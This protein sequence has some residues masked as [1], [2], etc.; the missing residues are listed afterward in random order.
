MKTKKLVY[1]ALFASLIAI[2]A[3]VA[4]PTQPIPLNM[5]LFAVLL[6]GGILGKKYGTLS[7]VVYILLGV[8]GIPVFAGFRG[9]LSVLMGPTG[10]FIVGY[11]VVAYITGVVYERTR[12]IK[13]TLPFMVMSVILCYIIGT[14]WYCFIMNSSFLTAISV[15]VFPFIAGDVLKIILAIVFLKKINI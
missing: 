2:M 5:A 11:I 8:A 6:A 4:I 15:C 3:L 12:E 14:I 9:G 1:S 7:V 10:G 13:Y